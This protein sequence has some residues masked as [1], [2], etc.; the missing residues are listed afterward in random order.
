MRVKLRSGKKCWA[1]VRR[2]LL[3]FHSNS[4]DQP[5]HPY[6]D[7]CLTAPPARRYAKIFA[8][9]KN[10]MNTLDNSLLIDTQY[11]WQ[12][13]PQVAQNASRARL[14]PV[15]GHK[16]ASPVVRR[17]LATDELSVPAG[18]MAPGPPNR[19]KSKKNYTFI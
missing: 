7:P 5:S 6:P 1:A 11:W 18:V 2:Q 3:M 4:P 14:W 8:K 16:P 10:A 19:R 13:F 12:Y 15:K 9:I 17:K